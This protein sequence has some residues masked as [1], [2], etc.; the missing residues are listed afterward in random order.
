MNVRGEGKFCVLIPILCFRYNLDRSHTHAKLDL[1]MT[2]DSDQDNTFNVPKM[3]T[4]TTELSEI[5]PPFT[6]CVYIAL[7]HLVAIVSVTSS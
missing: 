7:L 6:I 2:S 4:L 1:S 5:G 3:L